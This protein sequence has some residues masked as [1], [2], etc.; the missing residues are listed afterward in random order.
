MRTE[1]VCRHSTIQAHSQKRNI[2]SE[3]AWSAHPEEVV[4]KVSVL[5]MRLR[6]DNYSK[7]VSKK[8]WTVMLTDQEQWLLGSLRFPNCDV[9]GSCFV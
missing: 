2:S 3:E 1:Q 6:I 5:R 4:S 9:D 8:F 7:P